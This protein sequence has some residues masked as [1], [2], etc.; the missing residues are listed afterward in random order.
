ME[1]HQVRYFLAAAKTLSFTR[2]AEVCHVSQHPAFATGAWHPDCCR[3]R[4]PAAANSPRL[5]KALAFV[6]SRTSYWRG[7]NSRAGS[8]D[9]N[10]GL[11]TVTE[12]AQRGA[13]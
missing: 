6:G 11:D 12:S 2:A 4:C 5:R 13:D 9:H 1:M 3:W 7:S 10:S 8:I